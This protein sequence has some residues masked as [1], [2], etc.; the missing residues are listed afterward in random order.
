MK[1]NETYYFGEYRGKR[2]KKMKRKELYARLAEAYQLAGSLLI[3][4]RIMEENYSDEGPT[5]LVNGWTQREV[6]D[7]VEVLLDFLSC[8]ADVSPYRLDKARAVYRG[9]EVTPE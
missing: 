1:K 9:R 7:A 6:D 8:P 3:G 2:M 4:A 5:R